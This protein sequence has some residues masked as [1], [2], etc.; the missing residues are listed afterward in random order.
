MIWFT[1]K[2]HNSIRYCSI[3]PPGVTVMRIPWLD[4]SYRN[5]YSYRNYKNK[6]ETWCVVWNS[7]QFWIN[8]LK[9]KDMTHI[10]Q[11]LHLNL[12]IRNRWWP[13]IKKENNFKRRPVGLYH[14]SP[15]STVDKTHMTPVCLYSG[16]AVQLEWNMKL[17]WP[18]CEALIS[19][20]MAYDHFRNPGMLEK[21]TQVYD[22]TFT[23]VSNITKSTIPSVHTNMFTVSN[24]LN[25][26]IST[27]PLAA[28]TGLNTSKCLLYADWW[29]CF[30]ISF[31]MK[32]TASGSDIWVSRG[33]WCW[34]LKGDL[35]KVSAVY[36]GRRAF[37][38]PAR[39]EP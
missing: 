27:L 15:Y 3:S 1:E 18:H 31:L 30:S 17:W 12:F 37:T 28:N 24:L 35:S 39:S 13:C 20:L 23:H 16:F 14:W 5:H 11:Q 4:Y 2:S 26:E 21:F 7:I 10:V 22:Y 32:S 36:K 29:P 8:S 34:I 25:W 9:K 6:G 33:K 19:Y 38:I